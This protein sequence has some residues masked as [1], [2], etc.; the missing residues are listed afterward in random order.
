MEV[1]VRGLQS[2]KLAPRL[3]DFGTTKER[4]RVSTEGGDLGKQVY[5]VKLL[6][7]SHFQRVYPTDIPKFVLET[8]KNLL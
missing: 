4:G 5:P 6:D 2:R 8:L 7:Q 1:E 3:E